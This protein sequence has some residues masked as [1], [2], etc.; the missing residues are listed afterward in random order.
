MPFGA[1]LKLNVAARMA[2]TTQ[3]ELLRAI[4]S[5]E[6]SAVKSLRSGFDKYRVY[7]VVLDKWGERHGDG[8]NSNAHNGRKDK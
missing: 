2:G 7:K 6:L 4:Q 8:K 1:L 3:A 5:G